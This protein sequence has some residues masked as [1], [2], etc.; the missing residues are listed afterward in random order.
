LRHD[1]FC[2]SLGEALYVGARTMLMLQERHGGVNY[3]E[4]RDVMLCEL[5]ELGDIAEVSRLRLPSTPRNR[6]ADFYPRLSGLELSWLWGALSREPAI[7]EMV[8]FEPAAPVA[9]L[10]AGSQFHFDLGGRIPLNVFAVTGGPLLMSNGKLGKFECLP[11]E[12]DV[13]F[14]SPGVSDVAL[15]ELLDVPGERIR[16]SGKCLV[17]Q[18]RSLNE[19]YTRASQY[20]ER[21]RQ[22]HTGNV[23]EKALWLVEQPLERQPYWESM[24]MK[25]L[26]RL[27]IHSVRGRDR[28]L[29][30]GLVEEGN[31]A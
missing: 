10:P 27:K 26:I 24:D 3:G 5:P 16:A 4:W 1:S 28:S 23:F 11:V 18:V 30:A 12:A 20:R 7:T 2:R 6:R 25:P 22:S 31:V 13:V 19:A 15:A 8:K 21:H 14:E 29:A 17:V 9:V